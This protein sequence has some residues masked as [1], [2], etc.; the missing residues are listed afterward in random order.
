MLGV[1]GVNF[2]SGRSMFLLVYKK[3]LLGDI[4]CCFACFGELRLELILNWICDII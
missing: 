3:W 2:I 4:L 1:G